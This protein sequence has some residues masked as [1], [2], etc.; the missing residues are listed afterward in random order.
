MLRSSYRLAVSASEAFRETFGSEVKELNA[1]AILGDSECSFS[2][3]SFGLNIKD[4]QAAADAMQSAGMPCDLL[5]G[6][7]L[8]GA[9]V[10]AAAGGIASARAVATIAAPFDVTHVLRFLDP[11]GLAQLDAQPHALVRVASRP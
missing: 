3:A 6:H 9:A 11:V 10:L 5:I 8:G 4:L 7:S 2:D 1:G